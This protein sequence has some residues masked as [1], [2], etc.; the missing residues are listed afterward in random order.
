MNLKQTLLDFCSIEK[1]SG[2]EK[3]FAK[4]LEK[5][6]IPFSSKVELTPHGSVVAKIYGEDETKTN[7]TITAHIDEIGF[8]VSDITENGFL[9]LKNCGGI[10]K[11]LAANQH[12]IVYGKKILDGFT[13]IQKNSNDL[14]ADIGLDKKEAKKLVNLGDVA[15]FKFESLIFEDSRI[16]CKNLDDCAGVATIFLILE[17]IKK[18]NCNITVIF[19]TQEETS[20]VGILTANWNQ[21]IDIAICID[22]SFA[23]FFGCN[24]ETLGQLGNGT[25]IGIS[26][27]LD[28]EISQ[29]LQQIAIDNNIP[30]QLE[31]M[32]TLTSTDADKIIMNR[33]GVKTC[34][35][36]IPLR[37]M[38]SPVEM[39]DL[40]DIENTAN[41][42]SNF[43][44]SL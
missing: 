32:N 40:K 16:C 15:N 31:I 5:I 39:I 21:K 20:G 24:D 9:K 11:N 42:I 10:N 41:L 38:H 3:R 30:Y 8:I 22:V 44:N 36:S 28:L 23:Q 4:H 18:P 35:C 17:K 27:V 6:L 19:S 12:I 25:M 13:F 34:L 43:I 29:K 26:P 1:V 14:F 37:Y 2:H 33:N 7:V